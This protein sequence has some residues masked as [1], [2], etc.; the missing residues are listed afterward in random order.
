MVVGS[1][2]PN[3]LV[4]G[5]GNRLLREHGVQVEEHVL[6]A[7]CDRLNRA[8]LKYISTGGPMW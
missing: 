8:F 5:K 7:Q 6:Q 4:A 1:P 2:D 3:P